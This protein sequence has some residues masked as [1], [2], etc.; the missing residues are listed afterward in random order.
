MSTASLIAL[1]AQATSLRSLHLLGE[2]RHP[3][4]QLVG[5]AE[6]SAEG[7]FR[8]HA[9]NCTQRRAGHST[10]ALPTPRRCGS[11]AASTL[12]WRPSSMPVAAPISSIGV[13]AWPYCATSA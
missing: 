12:P 8:A 7:V 4:P 1:S 2:L 13:N 3:P 11:A 5:V 9:T 6:Q 10:A